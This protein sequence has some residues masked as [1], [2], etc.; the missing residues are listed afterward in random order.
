MPS[1][2]LVWFNNYF[3]EEEKPKEEKFFYG[4]TNKKY[5]LFFSKPDKKRY[6]FLVSLILKEINIK[7]H[8]KYIWGLVPIPNIP[9]NFQK[10]SCRSNTKN[11][12]IKY[13]DILLSNF[14]YKL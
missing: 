8:K 1:W 13:L 3:F 6:F 4:R 11:T 2:I 14:L 7:F 9:Q 10:K 12:V 5:F